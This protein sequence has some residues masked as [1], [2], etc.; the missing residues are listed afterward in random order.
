MDWNINSTVTGIQWPALPTPS[1]AT[2]LAVLFQLEQ[3]QWWSEEKLRQHQFS[4]LKP[5]LK[6]CVDYVPYYKD[7]LQNLLLS[8]TLSEEEW[9]SIPLLTRDEVQKNGDLLRAKAM[10]P[11][12]GKISK[13]F[14]SGS[15]GKPVEV[16]GTDITGFFWNVFTLRDHL[17]HKRNLDGK[18][19]V[20]RR[21]M[22][23]KAKPPHGLHSENWGLATNG[24]IKTGPTT[25][26]NIFTPISEQVEWLINQQPDCLLT[27]PSV[28][29]DLALYC[30]RENIEFPSLREV[31]TISEALPDGLRELCKEAWGAKLVDVYS[32]I[33]L[34]YLAIQCPEHD[35]YHIQSEGVLIEILDENGRPCSPG[36]SGR[37][38]VTNLHNYATPLIR[39]E[40]GDYAEVGEPCACGR[41]LPVIKRIQGR[42]RGMITLPSGE[43]SWPDLG[44]VKLQ[45]IA[46]IQQFQ[47]VQHSLEDIEVKLV[48]S[49]PIREQEIDDLTKMFHQTLRHPFNVT[50]V[51]LD[52]IPRSAGGKYE[53]FVSL[54]THVSKPAKT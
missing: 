54:L 20:I 2:R 13:Q 27:N 25:M 42:Y 7:K 46:P 14:T 37:V 6:H 33:E 30:Q 34:G 51:Q 41:G 38:V 28:L 4:Q 11:G 40:L 39:Y 10:P 44:I 43:R 22:S 36:E 23:E 47:V 52:D 12:H 24:L 19:A 32:S 50:I 1:G 18:L 31:R 3:S 8:E 26:I 15:T 29:Q 49:R 9:L 35:H 21:N 45:N 5:L 17:W 48:L 16:L 53:E